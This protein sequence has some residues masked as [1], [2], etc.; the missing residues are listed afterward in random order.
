TDNPR[1]GACSGSHT[2]SAALTFSTTTIVDSGPDELTVSSAINGAGGL[3]KIGSGTL[4]LSNS[5][6]TYQ[7]NTTV[8]EGTLE[9]TDGIPPN[10]T[11]LLDIQSGQAVFKTTNVVNDDLSVHTVIGSSLLIADGTHTVGNITGTG[12]TVLSDSAQLTVTSITQKTLTI[13]SGGK[14][15]LSPHSVGLNLASQTP[16]SVPEPSILIAAMGIAVTII[17]GSVFRAMTLSKAILPRND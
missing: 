10:S 9:I 1:I 15:T 14:V 11:S 7:G 12:S 6:N 2:I 3:I 4:S 5:N 8:Q 17:C 16:Q 13:G